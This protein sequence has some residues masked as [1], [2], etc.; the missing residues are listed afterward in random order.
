MTDALTEVQLNP[1]PGNPVLSRPVVP[2]QRT[3]VA[4]H[5][6]PPAASRELTGAL[7]M[8]WSTGPDGRLGCSWHRPT[9]WKTNQ[10]E[11]PVGWRRA[12]PAGGERS[13][14]ARDRMLEA[15]AAF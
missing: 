11:D 6:T 7:S 12:G 8:W 4:Q 1:P 3:R 14:L 5:A 10:A 13:V 2:S 15:L 9:P